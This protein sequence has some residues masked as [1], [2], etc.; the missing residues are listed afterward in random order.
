MRPNSTLGLAQALCGGFENR[1]STGPRAASDTALRPT[2][3]QST[4][5]TGSG[6]SVQ[7]TGEAPRLFAYELCTYVV[8]SRLRVA[9][10]LYYLP[11]SETLHVACIGQEAPPHRRSGCGCRVHG[12]GLEVRA[13]GHT[14]DILKLTAL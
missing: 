4:Y 8:T 3:L 2:V 5:I 6:F 9:W 12:Y 10:Y 13:R 11:G 7:V 14:L 1:L